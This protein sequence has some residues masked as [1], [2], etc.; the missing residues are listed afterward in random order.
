MQSNPVLSGMS[1]HSDEAP[2]G[3]NGSG[4]RVIAGTSAVASSSNNRYVGFLLSSIDPDLWVGLKVR[5]KAGRFNGEIACVHR[6][7]NGWLQLQLLERCDE[8]A[9]RASDL[10][11]VDENTAGADAPE[12]DVARRVQRDREKAKTIPA[13]HP[14]TPHSSAVGG[15][16]R[17]RA[18]SDDMSHDLDR[19]RSQGAFKASVSWNDFQSMPTRVRPPIVSSHVREQ[20]RSYV[21]KYVD[22]QAD[23]LKNRPNL[24]YWKHCVVG[25]LIDPVVEAKTATMFID[26]ICSSCR[27]EMW[28]GAKFCWNQECF[29]SPIYW[30]L[31]GA[32]GTPFPAPVATDP[33]RSVSPIP[34]S[35]SATPTLT[36]SSL[37]IFEDI[38]PN[39]VTT[40]LLNAPARV[41]SVN[42]GNDE[43]CRIVGLHTVGEACDTSAENGTPGE[44]GE[45]IHQS[46]ERFEQFQ[47]RRSPCA[48]SAVSV[49][50]SSLRPS[51]ISQPTQKRAKRTKA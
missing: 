34:P 46:A 43:D 9:K 41:L 18:Y 47:S 24:T 19:A 21:Q 28:P 1:N 14:V 20:R 51:D 8:V 13:R 15:R 17:D 16:R 3:S 33:H 10:E 5:I 31:P 40:Y 25:S 23:R 37:R 44:N 26:S 22:R 48:T 39:A 42:P 45:H 2:N 4:G 35:L 27:S 38:P 11:V 30:Q 7:G 6:S 49:C 50:E 36:Q 32:R 29:S 12:D